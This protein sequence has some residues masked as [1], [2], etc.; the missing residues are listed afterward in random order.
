[1]AKKNAK[2][3]E[4]VTTVKGSLKVNSGKPAEVTSS[5][6]AYSG[7]LFNVLKEQVKEP[8]LETSIGSVERD[9]IRHNGSVVILAV[10]E[11]KS[12]KDPYIVVE[13]QYRHA[14]GQFLYE[15]PAGKVDAGEERLAAAKRELI[16][17]TGFRAKKWTKLARYYASP[18]FLGEWMQ[19]YLAENLTLG[20]AAPEADERIQL[21][22]VPLSELLRLI[23]TGKIQD[24]KTIIAVLLYARLRQ[25]RKKA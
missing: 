5:E 23:D 3:A 22:L 14:A 17:E 12:K 21:F 11:S 7:P 19:V 10:D 20:D 16:E 13:R 1:M 15:V 2:A 4:T 18:G 9:I 24:G 6:I 8:G 25:A